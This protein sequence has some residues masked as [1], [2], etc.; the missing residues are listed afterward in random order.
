MT[1]SRHRED[2][3]PIPAW[4][5]EPDAFEAVPDERTIEDVLEQDAHEHTAEFCSVD[6]DATGAKE[7]A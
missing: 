4:S 5:C 1:T 3:S 6:D 2:G 7:L